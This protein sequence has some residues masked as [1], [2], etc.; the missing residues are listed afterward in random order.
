M[1][2]T[3]KQTH[4]LG[5]LQVF[6]SD[7]L[8]SECCRLVCCWLRRN[9]TETIKPLTRVIKDLFCLPVRKRGRELTFWARWQEHTLAHTHL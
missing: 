6:K 3:H 9:P 8:I 7:E 4:T 5:H 2:H 1:I